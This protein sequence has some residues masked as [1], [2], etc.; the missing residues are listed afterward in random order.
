MLLVCNGSIRSFYRR[1]ALVASAEAKHLTRP[2][3]WF[4]SLAYCSKEKNGEN[5]LNVTHLMLRPAFFFDTAGAQ[6]K[7]WQK[8]NAESISRLRAR[9][10]ALP[11]EPATFLKKGRSKT[12]KTGC[13]YGVAK[14]QGLSLSRQ[15][16]F[17]VSFPIILRSDPNA[18]YLLP[19][20]SVRT[21]T[22]L[23]AVQ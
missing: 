15:P 5:F 11:L 7:A 8:R 1:A 19:G 6:K 23:P 14:Q 9:P 2:F 20:I 22:E 10:R 16:H 12:F 13:P 21:G 4:F 18:R 17:V 3:F